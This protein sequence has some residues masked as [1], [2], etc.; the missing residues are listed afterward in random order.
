MRFPCPAAAAT[1][2]AAADN[3]FLDPFGMGM[4]MFGAPM[5]ARGSAPSTGAMITSAA[6][7]CAAPRPPPPQCWLACML[8][9]MHSRWSCLLAD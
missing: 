1:G 9:C 7:R 3:P 4:G 6:E 5:V 2:A 8:A